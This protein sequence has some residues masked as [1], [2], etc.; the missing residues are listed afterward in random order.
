MP[1]ADQTTDGP[2]PGHCASRP[3][4]FDMPVRSGPCHCGQSFAAFTATTL[5]N[6]A[7]ATDSIFFIAVSLGGLGQLHNSTTPQRPSNSP[8][9]NSQNSQLTP[10]L[11]FSAPSLGGF[12]RWGLGV[13][14]EL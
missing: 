4:S 14:W 9:P 8:T 3:I 11:Q 7:A 5:S 10:K 1:P 13:H 6:A 2:L 12:A